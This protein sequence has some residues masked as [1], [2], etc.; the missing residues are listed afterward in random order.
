[1][2]RTASNEMRCGEASSDAVVSAPEIDPGMFSAGQTDQRRMRPRMNLDAVRK[3]ERERALWEN[4]YGERQ[5]IPSTLRPSPSKPMLLY[6]G[7]VDFARFSPVL[8]AG[9]GNGRNAIHLA[10]KGCV[11]HA[12]DFSAAALEVLRRR[13]SDAGVLDRIRVYHMPLEEPWPL[14]S[15]H[16]ALVLDSYVSCH[17]LDQPSREAY[18]RELRRVLRPSGILYSSVFCVD[19][20]YYRGFMTSPQASNVVTDPHNGIKK[21]LYTEEEFREFFSRA[22]TIVYFAKFQ[23][24]DVVL[25]RT[26]RRSVLTL[27]LE[28]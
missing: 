12:V 14:P 7:L 18:G 16:F 17:V 21:Y 15:D 25:G 19:D 11:V 1:M 26:Y 22:L 23:F 24:D 27:L 13:A 3:L 8:D 9:C 6:E 20:A 4:E 28:K 2:A 10:A 5:V